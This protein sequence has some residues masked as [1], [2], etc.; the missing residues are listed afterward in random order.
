MTSSGYEACLGNDENVP[1]SDRG[2]LNFVN[3]L[4]SLRLVHRT[5]TLEAGERSVFQG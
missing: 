2:L 5:C 1:E 3:L 4:K